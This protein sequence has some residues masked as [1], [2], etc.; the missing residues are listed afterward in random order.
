MAKR[1]RQSAFEDLVEIASKLPWQVG[2]ALAAASYLALHAVAGITVDHPANAGT[3][4]TYVIK[5][6]GVTF[7]AIGQMIFPFCFLVGAGWSFF[8][9][10]QNGAPAAQPLG[11]K[12]LPQQ[13]VTDTPRPNKEASPTPL[14]PKCNNPMVKRT[15]KKGANAGKEFWGCSQYPRCKSVLAI[16]K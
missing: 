3:T 15:A 8:K 4:G 16:K 10:G 1:K 5:Q 12:N 2:L 9:Q 14:C 11:K 6:F 7:A 13:T